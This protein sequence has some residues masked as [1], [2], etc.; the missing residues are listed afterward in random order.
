MGIQN[1]KGW[2]QKHYKNAF[3]YMNMKKAYTYDHVYIDLNHFLHNASYNVVSRKGFYVKLFRSLTYLL[4]RVV[5]KKT[6]NIGIDGPSPFAK[7]IL[8]RKRRQD[9]VYDGSEMSSLELTPGTELMRDINDKL[10]VFLNKWKS[11]FKYNK[12]VINVENSDEAGEGEIKVFRKLKELGKKNL[13]D[14]HA[15]IGNDADLI[16][17]AMA[18]YPIKKIDILVKT[19]GYY[20]IIS[21]ERLI[22][23]HYKLLK[24]RAHPKDIRNDFVVLSI[25]MG[26][27]YIKKVNYLDPI[28]MCDKYLEFRPTQKDGLTRYGNFN[29]DFFKRF[30]T[31][32]NKII[33]PQFAKIKLTKLDEDLIEK[34]LETIRWCWSLYDTGICSKYDF[35]Y[36]FNKTPSPSQLIYYFAMYPNKNIYIPRSTF[37]SIDPQIYPLLVFNHRSKTLV[38]DK[39]RC[40]YDNE[41]KYLEIDFDAY[42]KLRKE[43]NDTN[44]E[45]KKYKEDNNTATPSLNLKKKS[46]NIKLRLAKFKDNDIPD[47]GDN[48]IK[49]IINLANAKLV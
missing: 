41:V 29:F 27:D 26:N 36:S 17:L 30:M 1:Y 3:L 40:M 6:L 18:S 39:L 20:Q 19:K 28:K 9:A 10:L 48:D 42:N 25:M 2:L 49:K 4:Y 38:C 14:S 16:V 21:I 31:H 45:I 15:V 47:F 13:N 5:P 23:D 46:N 22:I 43:Y 24:I 33:A 7:I 8:Q 37:L 34:Y 35:S 32:C 11:N 44:K 12:V